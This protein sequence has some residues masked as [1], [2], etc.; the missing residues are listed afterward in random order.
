VALLWLGLRAAIRVR[1]PGILSGLLQRRQLLSVLD[2]D[3][4]RH[5]A[6]LRAITLL[7]RS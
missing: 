1:I 7:A 2:L 5:D 4:D 3:A 6:D